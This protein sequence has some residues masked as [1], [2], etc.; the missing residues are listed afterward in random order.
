MRFDEILHGF[1]AGAATP[2]RGKAEVRT[3][4]RGK[5][6][7]CSSSGVH[8]ILSLQCQCEDEDVQALQEERKKHKSKFVPIPNVPVPT[9][10]VIMAAQAALRKLKNHQFIKMWYWTNDGLDAADCL[11]ANVVDD[12][13]LSLITMAEGLP[14]SSPRPQHTTN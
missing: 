2:G 8:C 11:K 4:G 3:P 10:P 6:S 12:C 5:R 7:W 1:R 14:T 9:E 13:L